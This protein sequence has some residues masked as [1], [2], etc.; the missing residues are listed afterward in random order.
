[1]EE[2][3]VSEEREKL[4]RVL[5]RNRSRIAYISIGFALALV[6]AAVIQICILLLNY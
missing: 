5:N 4:N 3:Y 1:L 2:G 6:L